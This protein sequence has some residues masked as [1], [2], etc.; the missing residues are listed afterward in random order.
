MKAKVSVGR[1][2]SENDVRDVRNWVGHLVLDAESEGDPFILAAI[3]RALFGVDNQAHTLRKALTAE[4][5]RCLRA[6]QRLDKKIKQ[7]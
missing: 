5:K 6:Q 1:R 2:S 7:Q 3:Y 4:A